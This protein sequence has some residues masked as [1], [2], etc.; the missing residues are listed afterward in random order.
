MMRHIDDNDISRM[1][2]G[3]VSRRERESFQKHLAQCD[4]CLT[5]YSESLKFRDAGDDEGIAL[6]RTTLFSMEK[7]VAASIVVLAVLLGLF[8]LFQGSGKQNKNEAIKLLTRLCKERLDS[9]IH[10][11]MPSKKK[12]FVL[13]RLGILWEDLSAIVRKPGQKELRKTIQSMLAG[14]IEL[15]TGVKHPLR[16]AIANVDSESIQ[17]VES[18]I[19]R[20]M[21]QENYIH[22]FRFGC[23][24]ERC[25]FRTFDNEL[26]PLQEIEGYRT[27][28]EANGLPQGVTNKLK[29][30]QNIT[31]SVLFRDICL[32]IAEIF[33]E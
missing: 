17:G 16:D 28:A 10:S 2:D 19:V 18:R 27:L 31:D 4:E 14:H 9:D 5:V 29:I 22:W 15:I 33:F 32:N 7:L 8:F 26:P 1:I 3:N 6:K 30:L 23:F 21:N 13:V 25:V 20:W 11:F 12:L 24:L